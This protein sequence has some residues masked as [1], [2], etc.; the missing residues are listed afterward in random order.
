MVRSQL[1]LVVFALIITALLHGTV[2][3]AARLAA[4]QI[5]PQI[6]LVGQEGGASYAVALRGGYAYLGIGPRLAV[7]DISAPA[8]PA[9]D[10]SS[11]PLPGIVQG[12]AVS[13]NY[14]YVVTGRSGLHIVD[15]TNAS[16][17][18]GKGSLDTPGFA[19]SVAVAGT[20]AYVADSEGGLRIISISDALAPTQVAA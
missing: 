15:V 2:P 11:A 9:L 5:E 16:S 8:T 20:H 4:P 14:A 17:P 13:G 19:H 1:R 6:G 12:L 7:V 18:L 3:A 10:G